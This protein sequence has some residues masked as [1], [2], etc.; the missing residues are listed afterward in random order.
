MTFPAIRP[1]RPRPGLAALG[2]M[3]QLRAGRLARRLPQLFVGLVLYGA[4]MALV[5]RSRLGLMPWDVLHYGLARHLPLNFGEVVI[6]VSFVVLLLW[7][8]LR[9]APGLG[10]IANAVVIGLATN[11]V[12]A[13]LGPPAQLWVRIVMLLGGVVLNGVATALYIGA[14]LGP[15]PRD[16]LMTG[17]HRRTGWSVRS[18]RTTLEVSVV[19][20]GWLLG[21]VV[22][23]GTVLYAV[24][25][26]P[27]VQ[28]MLPWCTVALNRSNQPGPNLPMTGE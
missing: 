14:Q 8:P 10:T 7:W 12:L 6:A 15:G 11:A 27:L 24:S 4:S 13:A 3:E 23:L 26:G 16:G 21:G 19:V 2:P 1:S 17:L 20:A 18:V 25:I 5:V 28:L 22:G 9:Q